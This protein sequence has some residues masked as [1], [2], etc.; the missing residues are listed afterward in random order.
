MMGR[1][2]MS[3]LMAMVPVVAGAIPLVGL[4]QTIDDETGRARSIVALYEYADDAGRE[5]LGGR[6]VAL[7]DDSG[8]ISETP[9]NATRVASK[10]A[11]KPTVVG[12]DIIWTMHWDADKN[13]YSGGNIMDP[14]N[15]KVY[16]SVIWRDG[17]S[18]NVRGKIGPFGRT[19]K[20]VP[21]AAADA[22]ASL[23]NLDT[24]NWKPIIRK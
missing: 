18:L 13:Q 8:N 24:S 15:G 14:A 19:Q 6:V 1:I 11:G 16:G 12:M 23:Q 7:Y 5:T 9:D 10:V 21:V 2:L 17:E 20:W 22:P 3:A 4:Y